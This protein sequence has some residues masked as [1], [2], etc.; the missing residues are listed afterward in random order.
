[1]LKCVDT[2]FFTDHKTQT[3][4]IERS[5]MVHVVLVLK[6]QNL[7]ESLTPGSRD[8]FVLCLGLQTKSFFLFPE[9]GRGLVDHSLVVVDHFLWS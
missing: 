9:G 2:P 4:S 3:S 1:M 7:A 6:F 8:P 5:V